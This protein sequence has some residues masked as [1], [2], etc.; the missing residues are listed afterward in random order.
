MLK[1]AAN[2]T[3]LFTE[4]PFMQRF[5]LA[6]AAGFNAVECQFPY[7]HDINDLK[8]QLRDNELK[9]VLFNLPAGDWAAGDR[10][11]AA[12]PDRIAEFRSGIIKAREYAKSLGVSQLNCLAGKRV[13]QYSDSR[14][15]SVLVENL[16]YAAKAFQQCG[17]KLLIEPINHFDVPDFFLNRMDQAVGLVEAVDMPNISIQYDIYHAWREGEDIVDILRKNIDRISHFQVADDPGRH[18]PGTGD[19]NYRQILREI[20]ETGYEG[21]IGLEYI[22]VVDSRFSFNWLS[23]YGYCL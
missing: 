18:E 23:A 11:I 12:H 5:R 2:L 19:I 9:Q 20:D 21:Y 4:V 13:P 14:Q 16:R 6:M 17:I 15:W 8:T 3:M 10:G 1:F 7:D 22:P